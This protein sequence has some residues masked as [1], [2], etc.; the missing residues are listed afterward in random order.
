[1]L[2]T[3]AESRRPSHAY[4]LCGAQGLGKKTLAR[5]FAQALLCGGGP[6]PCGRCGACVKFLKNVHPD[7]SVVKKPGDKTAILVEQIRA[8]REDVFIRPNESDWRVVLIEDADDMNLAAANALLKVLEEPPPYAV[9]LLTAKSRRALPETIASRCVTLEL[10]GVSA[11]EAAGWLR[12]RFPGLEGKE[13]WRAVRYGGGNL[14]KSLAFLEQD[15]VRRGYEQALALA[16]AL[17]ARREFDVLE[18]LAPFDGDREG[19]RRLLSDFDG[20][21]GRIAAAPFAPGDPDAEELSRRIQPVR[22]AALHDVVGEVREA[23]QYN[24]NC[25]LTAALLGA[26][27]KTVMEARAL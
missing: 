22:A 26:R 2:R 25:P 9:F 6:K 3:A 1:M 11:E 19:L 13:L 16:K 5:I 10:F 24:A 27:L 4:L 12:E 21:L 7:F 8:M 20:L 23:L 14:G 18:A 15:S 17:T